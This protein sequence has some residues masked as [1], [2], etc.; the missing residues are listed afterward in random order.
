MYT[1]RKHTIIIRTYD[2]FTKDNSIT[3]SDY[4]SDKT[5]DIRVLKLLAN[6]FNFKLFMAMH[7]EYKEFLVNSKIRKNGVTKYVS[8]FMPN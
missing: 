4:L 3:T 5:R 7:L 6:V 2:G 1:V 8:T